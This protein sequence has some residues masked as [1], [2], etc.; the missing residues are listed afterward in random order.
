MRSQRCTKIAD[1]EQKLAAERA[2][3]ER[4]AASE[5][6]ARDLDAVERALPNYLAASRR[7]ADALEKLHFHES[8]AMALFIG[9]TATQVEVAAGF[10]LVQLRGMVRAMQDGVAPI[11]AAKPVATSIAMTEPSP[12]TQMIFM[13][14]SVKY[15]HHNG[16]SSFVGQ[17]EDAD[18]PVA[19]A[20]GA[21]RLGVA[22]PVTD[23]KRAQLRGAR[24]GDHNPK[25][26]DVV[27][28]D[29]VELPEGGPHTD[30]VLR[31][32]NFTVIDRRA[33]ARTISIDVPRS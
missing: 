16:R 1:D 20:Q 3:A 26:A 11:P 6:L 21:L 17:F 13:L 4:K 23:P 31:A 7:F 8:G 29:A 10:A 2:A 25:A 5:Q 22:V 30:P 15:R 9:N 18:M 12:P 19:T 28:L 32:A 33:E 27:D 24:G 14:K